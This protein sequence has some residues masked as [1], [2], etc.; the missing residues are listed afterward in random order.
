MLMLCGAK[1]RGCSKVGGPLGG[2]A[3]I[4]T[5]HK[6]IIMMD[7]LK[8]IHTYINICIYRLVINFCCSVKQGHQAWQ[9]HGFIYQHTEVLVVKVVPDD[10]GN[11]LLSRVSNAIVV[12]E[13]N[14][15]TWCLWICN[16]SHAK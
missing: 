13:V 7:C 10:H 16:G 3:N 9:C 6:I 12:I 1:N 15:S 5:A 14:S 11:N 2:A 8:D 4:Y